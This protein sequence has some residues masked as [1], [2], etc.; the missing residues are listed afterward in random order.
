[1]RETFTTSYS[2]SPQKWPIKKEQRSSFWVSLKVHWNVK[3]D[4]SKSHNRC[5]EMAALATVIDKRWVGSESH[6]QEPAVD[7][8]LRHARLTGLP[9]KAWKTKGG[10]RQYKLRL[11]GLDEIWRDFVEYFKLITLQKISSRQQRNHCN[12]ENRPKERNFFRTLSKKGD[13]CLFSFTVVLEWQRKVI[14]KKYYKASERPA[15]MPN[16]QYTGSVGD[17]ATK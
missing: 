3:V 11:R 10:E 8:L 12:R 16:L 5:R 7:S 17:P 13:K 2:R 14:L 4:A 9:T 6:V 1:M 15:S